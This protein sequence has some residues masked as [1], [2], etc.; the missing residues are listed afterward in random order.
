MIIDFHVHCF[1]EEIAER[2]I[3]SLSEAAGLTP[4]SNGTVAGIKTSMKKAGVDKS[5]LLSIATKPQQTHKITQWAASVQDKN[6]IAFGSIHPDYEDWKDE[7]YRLCEAGIKGIKFHPEY[8]EFYVDDPKLFPIYEK[9]AELGLIIIFHA[10]VDLG[11]PAPYH[12]PP[13]RMKRVV[14]AFPGAKIV[15]AHMGG[16]DYW[17]E[18]ECCLAGEQLY[19]DTSF[20]LHK[21]GREQFLRIA[22]KHGYDRLLFATDSPWGDQ[23]E[24]VERLRGMMLPNDVT[25]AVFGGNAARL[26][27][28]TC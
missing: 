25:E 26:L 1:A 3:T 14:R 27:G 17:D 23:S 16:Y 13:E 11:F 21:M 7:L 5:V 2:A 15:A 6:I 22:S 8:Q 12:C 19:L 20:S 9:A 24:E 4:K 10:G 18:V 28:L